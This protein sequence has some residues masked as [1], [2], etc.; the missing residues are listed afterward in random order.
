MNLCRVN[1]WTNA[2]KN[3]SSNKHIRPLSSWRWQ[4]WISLTPPQNMLNGGNKMDTKMIKIYLYSSESFQ[5]LKLKYWTNPN[6]FVLLM[7]TFFVGTMSLSRMHVSRRVVNIFFQWLKWCK[8]KLL[9]FIGLAPG[10]DKVFLCPSWDKCK[11]VIHRWFSI[12]SCDSLS[13]VKSSLSTSHT[14]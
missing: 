3:S 11:F 1:K 2:C 6:L 12:L 10:Q 13:L 4:I 5:F 14:R 7:H 8:N 9:S